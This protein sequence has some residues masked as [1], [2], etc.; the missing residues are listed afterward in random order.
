LEALMAN[1]L[2]RNIDDDDLA[3]IDAHA[4]RLGLSRNE[5]LLRHLKQAV[6]RHDDTP[7]TAADFERFAILA[8]DLADEDVMRQAW[9]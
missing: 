8:A 2:I 5:F 4:A 7:V 9:S 3:L 1:I 6:P